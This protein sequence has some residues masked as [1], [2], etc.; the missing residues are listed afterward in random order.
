MTGSRAAGRYAKSLLSLAI[1]Q[2]VLEDVNKDMNFVA[3][4]CKSSNELQ[5]LLK[6]PIVKT[7]K[8]LSILK[9]LFSSNTG[10]LVSSFIGLITKKKR[11]AMVMDIAV[12]FN[13]QYNTYK[14][15]TSAKVSTAIALDKDLKSKIMAIV[16]KASEG[17]VLIEEEVNK[18]LIGGFIIKIGDQQV[19]SSIHSKLQKLKREFSTNA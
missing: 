19:D 7:E 2:N 10:K 14:K 11:E 18:D 8:K 12:S 15:I 1:E 5:L 17:D 6:S 16:K 4:T 3:S 13:E 9:A